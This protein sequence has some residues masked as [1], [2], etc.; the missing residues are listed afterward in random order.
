MVGP[1]GVLGGPWGD[2][3]GSL[4]WH[5]TAFIFEDFQVGR[6]GAQGGPGEGQGEG[7][8]PPETPWDP[9][10]RPSGIRISTTLSYHVICIS[11]IESFWRRIGVGLDFVG[12]M[13]GAGE[14]PKGSPGVPRSFPENSPRVS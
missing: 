1:W 13:P 4:G 14:F 11:A 7:A 12:A 5:R 2:P 3:W 6:V 10:V 8:V 9:W